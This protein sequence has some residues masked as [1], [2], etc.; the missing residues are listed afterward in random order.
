MYRHFCEPKIV[1]KVLST[2]SCVLVVVVV[3][4][5]VVVVVV[6]GVVVVLFR[7]KL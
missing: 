5:G 3:F 2:L 7:T 1:H 4:V 6:V